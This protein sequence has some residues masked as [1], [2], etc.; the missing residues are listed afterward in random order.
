MLLIFFSVSFV[1]MSFCTDAQRFCCQGNGHIM[2]NT[3]V[4]VK[5]IKHLK[6]FLVQIPIEN[7]PDIIIARLQRVCPGIRAV[8]ATRW[9]VLNEHRMSMF[10]FAVT[11][12]FPSSSVFFFCC[13]F[14]FILK[15]APAGNWR[16]RRLRCPFSKKVPRCKKNKTNKNKTATAAG[17]Q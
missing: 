16:G 3:L 4:K 7:T 2:Q 17:E 1:F 10:V 14:Y 5:V 13:K 9:H 6:L 11:P 15:E 8:L 12:F